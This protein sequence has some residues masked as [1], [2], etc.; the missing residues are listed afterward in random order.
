MPRVAARTVAEHRQQVLDRVYR[1]FEELIYERGYDAVT[2]ADIAKASGL[3]R[4]GIYNYFPEKEA[5]LVAYTAHEM[6][7]FFSGLRA[8]LHRVDHPLERLD[9]YVRAQLSYLGSH[10]LPP[11]P[12]MRSVLSSDGYQAI[13]AHAAV[14]EA[15]LSA[16]LDEAAAEGLVPAGVVDDRH[17]IRLV[18][19]C[20]T[21]GFPRGVSGEALEGTITGTQAFVRRAVGASPLP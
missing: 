3:A 10:H 16:I 15:T 9:T 4:T 18:L 7:E 6:D 19:T 13:Q 21:S 1:A 20:L 8:E 14:L 17:T 2:L 5:L 11:G 12:A